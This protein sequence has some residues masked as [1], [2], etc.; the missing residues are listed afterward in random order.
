M[1]S[2]RLRSVRQKLL[3]IVLL[4]NVF[5]LTAAG[6]SLLYYDLSQY[7]SN[8]AAALITLAGILGQSNAVALDFDDS[9]VANENLS[10]LRANPNIVTAAIFTANGEMFAAY[11]EEQ[12][13]LLAPANLHVDSFFFSNGEL[14]VTKRII[15]PNG[16]EGTVYLIQQFNLTA[17]LQDYLIILSTILAIALALSLFIS[18]RLQRW[19]SGPIHAISN[20]ARE[21]MEE[22]KYHLR[23]AKSTEDE[24]GQLTDDFNGMLGTLE[25]EIA[26][27]TT[28]EH[29]VRALNTK[30]EQRVAERTTELRIANQRLVSRTE[31][32]ETAN[33]AK[34]DFLANMSHEIRTPMNAILGL[35]YLLEQS[36][37]DAD[38][39]DLIKKIRNA[40][41]SLQ[42]IIND[43]LDLSKIEA[44]RLEIEQIP[45]NII[46]VI[47][48]LVSITSGNLG[49]KDIEL[50]ISPPPVIRGQ[51]IGDALRIEQVLINLVG[52]AIKF[53]ATGSIIVDIR[54]IAEEAEKV[55]LRFSVKDTGIGILQENQQQIFSAFT[56]ADVSTTRR[57]GGTGL[58][59]AICR[60]LV[61]LMGG[62]IGVISEAGKGSEFWFTLPFECSPEPDQQSLKLTKLDILIVDNNKISNEN[63]GHIVRSL[64]WSPT[65]APS[66]EVAIQK[67]RSKAESNNQ[68][69]AL[70]IDW[71][72]GSNGL[73]VAKMI[74]KACLDHLPPII[75]M[76][77]A[78][79]RD[80]FS[81]ESGLI[82]NILD[83]PVTSSS[84]YNII[85]DLLQPH[86][87][88]LAEPSKNRIKRI[89]DVHVLVVD[90]NVVN[91]EVAMRF[92][93]SE[94]AH[95]SLAQDG[96]EAVDWISENISTLDLVLMDVQMPL[97][98]GYEATR[99]L[100]A[101]PQ[102]ADLPIIALT[103]GVLESQL[104]AAREAGMN[105]V[106]TKPFN[107]NELIEAIQKLVPE[108]L[109]NISEAN[110]DND[111]SFNN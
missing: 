44:G 95:V 17:W 102:C 36:D 70:L 25:H 10:L 37:L 68:Y 38:S 62:E 26:E 7:R 106:V 58:G 22:R 35:A 104:D 92:L 43:V 19:I 39:A 13:E 12:I 100:R 15:T 24:I 108:K 61:T 4:A 53:T 99:H 55:Q 72:T 93:K 75:L 90:D 56:Q 85:S 76:M 42:S 98:D 48:N 9:T 74:Q 21:V 73:D 3:L 81:D 97:M 80:E 111:N 109:A 59:L 77:S 69:D 67:I 16:T 107:I 79:S 5:S 46:D 51:L 83:K 105:A 31:E 18:T 14:A 20:V 2:I 27:R 65:Q 45:F 96:K 87:K 11:G 34:A 49:Q 23:A 86:K 110:K 103:A 8:T 33:R 82:N 52:N 28:A 71:K 32:A 60:Q 78:F 29:E 88:A 94:G 50:I 66:A 57:F 54:T 64:S 40:G 89:P 84:L 101:L 1:N 47:D 6:G 30:L 91:R 63:L 41:R